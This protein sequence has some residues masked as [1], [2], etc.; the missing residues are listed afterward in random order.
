MG[1]NLITLDEFKAAEKVESL[2]NDDRLNSL[3]TSVSQLVKTYCANSF[4]DYYTV[5]KVESF[6]LDFLS[7]TLQVTESPLI[8][9]TQVEERPSYGAAYV[10]LDDAAFEYFVDNDTDT[11]QR[12]TTSGYAYWAM[13][14]G[15][16]RVTYKAGYDTTAVPPDLQLA[17]ID[18]INYYR[19]DEYKIRRTIGGSSMENSPTSTQWRSVDFPDH[20]KRVLDLYKQVQL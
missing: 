11:I 10:V 6:S 13:G 7:T 18:L 9:V 3:I 17:V 1:A 8:S 15:C 4:V 5:D 12:T 2:K 20:I 19:D 16:A 14:P